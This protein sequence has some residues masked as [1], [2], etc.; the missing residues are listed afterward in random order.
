MLK[1]NICE[2]RGL[3]LETIVAK[4]IYHLETPSRC[5]DVQSYSGA[6]QGVAMR[7]DTPQNVVTCS[8][9]R[10]HLL[11]LLKCFDYPTQK[12]TPSALADSC[13]SKCLPLGFQRIVSI[14]SQK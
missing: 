8:L 4:Q 9:R 13:G 1:A 6:G 10:A 7:V 5:E 3:K 14:G 12:H 11:N 2:T